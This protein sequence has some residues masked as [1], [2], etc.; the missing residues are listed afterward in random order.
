MV[1]PRPARGVCERTVERKAECAS[2]SEL[3]ISEVAPSHTRG[4]ARAPGTPVGEVFLLS[5][6]SRARYASLRMLVI[7]RR[8]GLSVM[9]TPRVCRCRIPPGAEN[10]TT[11]LRRSEDQT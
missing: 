2:Y 4:R 10:V 11:R 1:E 3:R 5:A 6:Q 9:T 8:Q 7:E